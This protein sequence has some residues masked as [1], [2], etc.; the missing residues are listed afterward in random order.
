MTDKDWRLV[1]RR[2]RWFA[3][4]PSVVLLGAG[5]TAGCFVAGALSP[6]MARSLV[7]VVGY[8]TFVS[9]P[10]RY[11][12]L[13]RVLL[14]AAQR[15]GR[16]LELR[17]RFARSS[18]D[19]AWSRWAL[20]VDGRSHLVAAWAAQIEREL[21]VVA[22]GYTGPGHGRVARRVARSFVA[23]FIEWCVGSGDSE[24][25]ERVILSRDDD[26][27]V[28]WPF[29]RPPDL[30][31]DLAR[32]LAVADG[33][34]ARWMV[35]DL[36][37]EVAIDEAHTAVEI[38]LRRALESGRGTSFPQLLNRAAAP[39][40]RLI[41]DQECGWLSRLNDRRRFIKHHGGVIPEGEEDAVRQELLVSL[42]AL[43]Q[44]EGRLKI[45]P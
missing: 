40:R 26:A 45:G 10:T 19:E 41:T 4:R 15:R 24:P 16:A 43:D 27:S 30:A 35:G 1:L 17:V 3:V 23:R 42:D 7:T 29:I 25:R 22:E 6:P 39:P 20:D 21:P 8:G 34:L 44:I 2:D 33:L 13:T 11:D 32:R 9:V 31:D 14:V 37:P 38:V 36:P 12:D 5:P 18:A 28:Y